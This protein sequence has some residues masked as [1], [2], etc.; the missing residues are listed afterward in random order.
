MFLL[1]WDNSAEALGLYVCAV[2]A[3][4]EKQ[5]RQLR[6]TWPHRNHRIYMS[7]GMYNF[8]PVPLP[9]TPQLHGQINT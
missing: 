2:S 1:I 5:S 6:F 7:Q 3:S 9:L 8:P 4:G